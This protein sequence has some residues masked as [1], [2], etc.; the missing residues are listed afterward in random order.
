MFLRVW[1]YDVAEGFTPEFER[2]YAAEGDWARLFAVSDGFLGTELFRRIGEPGRYLTVDRFTS[3]EA[4]RGFLAEHGAAYAELDGRT[5]GLTLDEQ[6]LAS[7][8]HPFDESEIRAAER[9]LE[10]ALEASDPTAWVYEYTEDAVFD[11][12][13]DHAVQ[14][15][16]ALLEMAGAMKPLSSVSIRPLRTEA[17]GDLA[18][19]WIEASWVSGPPSEGRAVDVRGMI[20]WRKERDGRWRVAVEHLG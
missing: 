16:E 5:E 15:R 19:V 3:S 14:G 18:T 4:W 8:E 12:G 1:Q 6:E 13:G 20:L 10:T 2:V 7:A 17:C 11:G 9:R